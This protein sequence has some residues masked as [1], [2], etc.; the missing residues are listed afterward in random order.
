MASVVTI[1]LVDVLAGQKA[2]GNRRRTDNTVRQHQDSRET[3]MVA[4][5]VPDHDLQAAVVYAFQHPSKHALEQVV[6]P[7]RA[8]AFAAGA[9]SGCTASASGSARRSPRPGWPP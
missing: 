2:L 6:E 1:D 8:F 4:Q 9:G 3:I 5:S 7:C